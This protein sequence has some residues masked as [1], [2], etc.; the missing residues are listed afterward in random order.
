MGRTGGDGDPDDPLRKF[1]EPFYKTG[2]GQ[3]CVLSGEKDDICD[4]V[5]ALHVARHFPLPTYAGIKIEPS[6]PDIIPA[7]NLIL[8]GGASDY[9]SPRPMRKRPRV[10]LPIGFAKL[11]ARLGRI[12]GE[13]CYAFEGDSSVVLVNRVTK[14][15]YAARERDELRRVVGY[16]VI[17]RV[18]RGAVENTVIFEGIHTPD[19]VGAVK[20]AFTPAIIEEVLR[21]LSEAP[22]YQPTRP[23]EILVRT[24]FHPSM[25]YGVYTLD[26]IEAT[27]LNIVYDRIWTYDMTGERRWVNQERPD[28]CLELEGKAPAK[29]VLPGTVIPLPYLEVGVDLRHVDDRV[30]EL[31]HRLQPGG[32]AQQASVGVLGEEERER[33]LEVLAR[34][35]D[36]VEITLH[37]G[38]ESGAPRVRDLPTRWT[39]VRGDRKKW[40][41]ILLACRDLGLGFPCNEERILAFFPEFSRRARRTGEALVRYFISSIN[42]KMRS[43]FGPLFEGLRGDK[44]YVHIEN[45]RGTRTYRLRLNRLRVVLKLWLTPGTEDRLYGPSHSQELTARTT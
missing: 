31:C 13:C 3:I 23:V 37:E 26:N 39:P 7:P 41:V 22:G 38:I 1:F 19:T 11:G 36:V 4:V 8:V 20:V 42:G 45:D 10:L 14:A 33:L 12:A 32:P 28:V 43:G 24:I 34:H 30:R 27:P 5:A 35:S 18:Y 44:N 40:L 16:G 15:L 2:N 25:S 6:R 9:V 29:A 17:R 21:A